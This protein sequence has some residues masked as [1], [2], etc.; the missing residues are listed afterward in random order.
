MEFDL[1]KLTPDV[2]KLDDMREVLADKDFAKNS[3]DMDSYYMYRKVEEKDGLKSSITITRSLMLGKEFNKTYGHIHD[4][5]FAETYTV[6]DGEGFFLMQN[7]DENKIEDVFVIKAQ[8]GQTA[9]IPAGYGH[10]TINPSTTVDLKTQDWTSLNCK[11]NYTLYK[12]LAGSCY[13]YTTEGWVK[14]ENYKNIPELR[15]EKALD[16]LP[17]DLTFLKG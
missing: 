2:R 3:P 13:Y 15:F 12:K 4:G 9:V 16:S 1:T 14:N 17:E 10:V 7:G 11:N 8:K 6:L 5:N